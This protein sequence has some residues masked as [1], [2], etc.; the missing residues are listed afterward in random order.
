MR[1]GIAKRVTPHSLRHSFAT[2]LLEDGANLAYVQKL[3]GH[4]RPETTMRYTRI[5]RTDLARIRSPLDNIYSE[6]GRLDRLPDQGS[7]AARELGQLKAEFGP[8]PNQRQSKT[9]LRFRVIRVWPQ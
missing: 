7:A 2:H 1:A 4:K 6:L 9:R 3:L 5:M 8:S